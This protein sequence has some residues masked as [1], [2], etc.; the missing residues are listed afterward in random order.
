MNAKSSNKP[1]AERYHFYSEVADEIRTGDLLAWRVNRIDSVFS[2][3]LYIYQWLFKATYSHTAIAVR[4]E[5]ELFAVEATSP[6]VRMMPLWMLGNFYLFRAGVPERKSNLRS[7]LKHLAKDYSLFDM[8]KNMFQ[9]GTSDE[10][11]YCA[12]QCH[13][14]YKDVGY[15]TSVIDEDESDIIT[16]DKVV[17]KVMKQSG[18]VPEYIRI[19]KGNI[20]AC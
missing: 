3:L 5:G 19:D 4:L 16:P 13:E 2:F 15:F 18:A 9:F 14:F 20:H 7:L 6:A 11:L 10:E 8:V 12:E 1:T 17:K